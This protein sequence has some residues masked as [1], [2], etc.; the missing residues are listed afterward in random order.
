MRLSIKQHISIFENIL[1]KG[2]VI[3]GVGKQGM[4][5]IEKLEIMGIHI[6]QLQI[7]K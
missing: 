4:A 3:Y 7:N 1:N 2:V 6:G 5:T